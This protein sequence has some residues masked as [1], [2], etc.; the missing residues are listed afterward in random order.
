MGSNRLGFVQIYE[1]SDR[2]QPTETEGDNTA[3]LGFTYHLKQTNSINFIFPNSYTKMNSSCNSTVSVSCPDIGANLRIY[4]ELIRALSTQQNS[5]DEIAGIFASA[6][7]SPSRRH[8]TTAE[9][10]MIDK[11][12]AFD[13]SSS[14]GTCFDQKLSMA[15]CNSSPITGRSKS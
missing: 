7:Q 12:C 6:G 15:S 8:S 2:D 11:D 1:G 9:C 14:P 3:S 5:G 10:E 13:K 4:H